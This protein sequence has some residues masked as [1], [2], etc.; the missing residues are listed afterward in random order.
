MGPV[1]DLDTTKSVL[2]NRSEPCRIGLSDRSEDCGLGPNDRRGYNA[3]K[4]LVAENT[5]LG[6]K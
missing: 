5:Y 3:D 1:T 6:A 2:V 4:K